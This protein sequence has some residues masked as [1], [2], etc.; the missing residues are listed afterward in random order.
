[1]VNVVK[2]VCGLTVATMAVGFATLSPD[3]HAGNKDKVF[4]FS[5]LVALPEAY[6]GMLSP[7][8]GVVGGGLPWVI[9]KGEIKLSDQGDLEVDVEGLIIDPTAD[10][11]NAGTNPI[12]SFKAI[13]SCLS[14][15][16]SNEADI[17]N[18]ETNTYPATTGPGAGD[19]KFAETLDLPDPC[20]APIVFVTSPG[21]AWFAATGF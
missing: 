16:A 15:N 19:S 10:S 11:P 3:A 1:M 6:T 2:I 9:D 18:V 4:E 5:E 20:I 8:R 7:I 13:V 17:V 14:V 12:A 21:G